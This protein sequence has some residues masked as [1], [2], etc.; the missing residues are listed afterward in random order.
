MEELLHVLWRS[1]FQAHRL[2]HAYPSTSCPVTVATLRSAFQARIAKQK[3]LAHFPIANKRYLF[4]TLCA[5][6]DFAVCNF[7][8]SAF[9]EIL[10]V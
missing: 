1:A 10:K 3:I 2:R 9:S 4:S 8:A 6:R 5:E 7:Y